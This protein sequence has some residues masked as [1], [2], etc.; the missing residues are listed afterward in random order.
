[1]YAFYVERDLI[2]N[3]VFYNVLILL[4]MDYKELERRLKQIK[5]ENFIWVIYIGIICISWYSNYLEKNYFL[6]N[7]EES[8]ESYRKLTIFIFSILVIIYIYFFKDSIDEIKELSV[9]DS[10]KKK[11]LTY[12]SMIGSI[13]ILISGFIFLYIAIKDEEINVE[14]AFN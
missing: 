3:Q 10:K 11:D 1:M 5:I 7:D 13:L 8:K 14:I 4:S 9:N 2:L 6:Y 12:L